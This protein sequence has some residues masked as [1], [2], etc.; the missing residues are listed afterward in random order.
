MREINKYD[1]LEVLVEQLPKERQQRVIA[2]AYEGTGLL[3]GYGFT[4]MI[5]GFWG[6]CVRGE[7]VRYLRRTEKLKDDNSYCNRMDDFYIDTRC[8][9]APR[10]QLSTLANE[11]ILAICDDY[12]PCAICGTATTETAQWHHDHRGKKGEPNYRKDW[13]LSE[14]KLANRNLTGESYVCYFCYQNKLATKPELDE[15]TAT[16]I[17]VAGSL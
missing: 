16:D 13:K 8:G 6:D 5:N 15:T 7:I 11:L 9:K 12:K 2:L 17:I 14:R 4:G 1:T 10:K 3:S